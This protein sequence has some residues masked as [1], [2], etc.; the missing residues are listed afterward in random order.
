[1]MRALINL[2]GTHNQ[3][4]ISVDDDVIKASQKVLLPALWSGRGIVILCHVT[5]HV[6]DMSF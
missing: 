4:Y 5:H 1:M 6:F 2:N 3:K